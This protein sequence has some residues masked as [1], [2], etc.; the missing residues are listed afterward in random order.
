MQILCEVV[1]QDAINKILSH[2]KIDSFTPE[3]VPARGPP[4]EEFTEEFQEDFNQE[5]PEESFV[6]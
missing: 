2:L 6:Q 3:L 5:Y 4:E 1:K